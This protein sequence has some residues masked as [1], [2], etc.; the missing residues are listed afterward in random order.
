M[1]FSK[2]WKYYSR[3]D[4]QEALLKIAKNREVIG[5]YSTGNFDTRPNVLMYPEDIIQMVKKGVVSFHGS[6]ELW[7]NPMSLTVG[8]IKPEMDKL[9][10]GWDLIIDPD[11]PDFEIAK[12]ATQTICQSLEDHGIKSYDLKYT[13]GK[14]FHVGLCFDSFPKTVNNQPT[15]TLY[16]DLPKAIIEYLKD[17]T[18]EILKEEILTLDNPMTI[19]KRV[20]KPIEDIVDENGVNPF[21][22]VD[23]DSMLVSP[24]HLFR[25][26]Y[27]LH[28][29]SLLVS[30]P[31]KKSELK[32]FKKEDAKPENIEVKTKFFLE[33]PKLKEA[34]GLVV[35]SMDWLEKYEK[36][37]EKVEY[38]RRKGVLKKI[39]EKFFPP[40]I[41]KIMKGGL[42]DGR[43][44]SVFLLI[45]FL[46]NMGWE[47]PEIEKTL[48]EWNEKNLPP[49]RQNYIRTQLR[50][51]I[52][53]PRNLLPPNCDG[54][55]YKGLGN[56]LPDDFCKGMKNPVNYPFRKMKRK[57]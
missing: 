12:V 7:S 17:Y 30:L 24:R 41:L 56:C 8:M 31:L 48:F 19:A 5:V 27:S 39:D 11:C 50:W 51:H 9:R 6:I 33:N 38:R 40:C 22:I 53:Q 2:I 29:K 23:V 45:T 13:G 28:E 15:E 37:E 32:N 46:R 52:R 47:W 55:F 16:P 54:D 14:S 10:I 20:G 3:K 44:R 49:S 57:T 26:P 4:V 25:L 36:K 1:S 35:E 21:K 43:K 42:S 18:R 34:S